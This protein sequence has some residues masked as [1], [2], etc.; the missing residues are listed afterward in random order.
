MT[1][2]PSWA[3]SGARATFRVLPDDDSAVWVTVREIARLIREGARDPE[4]RELARALRS[5]GGLRSLRRWLSDHW[6]YRADPPDIEL[7][8][9]A[10]LLLAEFEGHGYAAG[11]CDDAAVLAGALALAMGE[12]DVRLVLAGFGNGWA[13]VWTEAGG[14]ELDVTRPQALPYGA[15]IVQRTEVGV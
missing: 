9:A 2:L 15:G 1:Y 6:L 7:V 5:M 14:V 13:H 10:P 8:R 12:S 11:D 3:G 4:V